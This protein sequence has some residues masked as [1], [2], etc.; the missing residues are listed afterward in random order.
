[1][2][3]GEKI[4]EIRES[5]GITQKYIDGKLNKYAGWLSRIEN[6]EQDIMAKELFAIS[7]LLSTPL[8]V[9]YLTLDISEGDN[10]KGDQAAQ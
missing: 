5:K 3:I 9:F 4:K 1:M 7:K 10:G 2:S 8:E 6:N